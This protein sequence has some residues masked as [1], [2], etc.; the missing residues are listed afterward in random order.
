MDDIT[1][2]LQEAGA[3]DPAA[4]GALFSR[5]YGEL[6]RLAHGNL[7]RNGGREEL[8]TT[9]LVHEAYIKLAGHRSLLPTDRAA[10]FAYVAT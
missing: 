1:A 10:F 3:G 6:K 2:I 8:D 4:S 9:V 7:R 5:V